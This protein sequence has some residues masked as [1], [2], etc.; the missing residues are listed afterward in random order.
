MDKLWPSPLMM[1]QRAL[2]GVLRSIHA[3]SE[4]TVGWSTGKDH[5]R[6][7]SFFP[8]MWEADIFA[9]CCNFH[10]KILAGATE[11][12]RNCWI[13]RQEMTIFTTHN[14]DNYYWLLFTA[15]ADSRRRGLNIFGGSGGDWSGAGLYLQL[16][17]FAELAPFPIVLYV[18]RLNVLPWRRTPFQNAAATVQISSWCSPPVL[19]PNRRKR[20]Q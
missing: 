3:A 15:A 4:K 11:R 20:Q 18:F 16:T 10:D 6:L 1:A 2:S 14:I 12:H 8:M 13:I 9:A 17:T 7:F 19:D 5:C